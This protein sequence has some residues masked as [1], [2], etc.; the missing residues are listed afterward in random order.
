MRKTVKNILVACIIVMLAGI[1]MDS[2]AMSASQS[3]QWKGTISKEGDIVVVKNPKNPVFK[4]P[5]LALK[6]DFSIGGA[7]AIGDHAFSYPKDIALDR[8]GNIYVLDLRECCLKVFD[9]SAKYLRTIGR[10]GQGPGEFG[11]PFFLSLLPQ[12]GEIFVR[13]AGNRRIS[14]FN[15]SGSFLQ[16]V[17]VR[18]LVGEIRVDSSRNIYISETIFGSGAPQDVLKKLNPDMS[19]VLAEFIRH[20]QDESHEPFLV[21]RLLDFGRPG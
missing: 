3:P 2:G 21:Q 12:T 8:G 13:D 18:G 11:G 19:R 10:R 17:P 16:Q 6:E 20:P 5:I 14:S 15:I 7:G 1:S 9:P 4:E